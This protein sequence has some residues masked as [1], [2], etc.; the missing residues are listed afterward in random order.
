MRSPEDVLQ[1][2]FVDHGP[3]DWFAG[4]PAFDAEIA[5]TFADTLA[6]AARGETAAWRTS[7]EGR[8]AEIIVL[9]QFS[10]QIHRGHADAYATDP[11]ALSLA[12]EA[13]AAG[14]D[15][16]VKPERRMFFYLPHMHAEDI[17]VHEAETIPLYEKFGHPEGLKF[18][19]A[20]A[21]CLRRFGRYP[22]RNAPLGRVSTPEELAYL[23]SDEAIF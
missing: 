13:I 2:W 14:D 4:T 15:Q 3:D 1:F 6:A 8:L 7:P 21:D 12:R 20:H 10:R 5:A 16:Q 11:L 9:D 23:A 17:A 18:E 19:L 22:R